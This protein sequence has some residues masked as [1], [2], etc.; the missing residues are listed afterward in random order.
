MINSKYP[1]LCDIFGSYF[2]QDW[3]DEFATDDAALQTIVDGESLERLKS[4]CAEIDALLQI[5]MD[6]SGLRSFISV[7]LG[8]FFEPQSRNISWAEWL[9]H[10]KQKFESASR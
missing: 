5:G 1:Q 4:A 8:C 7:E 2:H 3:N 9:Q 10:V 6:E